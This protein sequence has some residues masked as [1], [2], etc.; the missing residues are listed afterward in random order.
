MF[1]LFIKENFPETETKPYPDWVFA[2]IVLLCVV[3]VV[4]IP[5]VAL[6]HLT[7]RIRRNHSDRSYPNAY[8]NEGFEIETQNTSA[9]ST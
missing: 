8:C 3:P 7:C 9:E 2:I 6:Y 1:V 5:I 4:P